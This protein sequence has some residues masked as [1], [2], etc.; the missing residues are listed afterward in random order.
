MLAIIIPRSTGNS[1]F[2]ECQQ[3]YLLEMLA[4]NVSN[5]LCSKTAAN[6]K[7]YNFQKCQQS[8]FPEML[9]SITYRNPG[10]MVFRNVSNYSFR[11]CQQPESG[12]SESPKQQQLQFPETLTIIT[13]R[14]TGNYTFLKYWQ[15]YL[16]EILATNASNYYLFENVDEC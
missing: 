7:D 16:L 2:L 6:V 8:Y 3:S 5:F 15:S 4:T 12:Q 13:F 10:N 1:N 11:K 14:N 9:T